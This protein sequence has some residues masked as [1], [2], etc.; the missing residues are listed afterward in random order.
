MPRVADHKFKA[1]NI[2][3]RVKQANTKQKRVSGIIVSNSMENDLNKRLRVKTGTECD[4]ER[5]ILFP[6]AIRK[7]RQ[8]DD[9]T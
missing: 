5:E 2:S 1:K 4:P 7:H 3:A 8:E 9:L 6:N